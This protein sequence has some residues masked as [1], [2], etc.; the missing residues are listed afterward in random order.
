MIIAWQLILSRFLISW[1]KPTL[2][3]SHVFTLFEL[4]YQNTCHQQTQIPSFLIRVFP[5]DIVNEM[6]CILN[7][8]LTAFSLAHLAYYPVIS[9]SYLAPSLADIVNMSIETGVFPAKVKRAKGIPVY[10]SGDDETDSGNYRPISLLSIF[11][12][13]L[14]QWTHRAECLDIINYS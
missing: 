14:K 5:A 12:R 2:V 8:K 3:A 13:I 4:F 1:T 9:A 7:N 10:K 6:L 11:N